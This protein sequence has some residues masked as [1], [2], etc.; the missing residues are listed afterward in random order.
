MHLPLVITLVIAL[1]LDQVF[2]AI[3]THLAIQYHLD[4]ILLLTIDESCGWGCCGSL[5]RDGIR[6]CGGQL[7]HSD[8]L[9]TTQTPEC[10]KDK[11][12]VKIVKRKS[13]LRS[14]QQP[15]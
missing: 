2:Q 11:Y 3:V 4:L 9:Y 13:L 14:H 1:P 8:N 15:V 6:K 12:N 10:T 5:A 7:D